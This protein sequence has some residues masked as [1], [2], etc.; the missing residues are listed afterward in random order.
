MSVRISSHWWQVWARGCS[1]SLPD[2]APVP[3]HESSLCLHIAPPLSPLPYP[4]FTVPFMGFC[5]NWQRQQHQ[6]NGSNVS[7]CCTGTAC[8]VWNQVSHNKMRPRSGGSN[9]SVRFPLEILVFMINP[10]T[11][12][13]SALLFLSPFIFLLL[14]SFA[15]SPP[16]LPSVEKVNIIIY[17][18]RETY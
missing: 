2:T 5:S 13:S 12:D 1:Q 10:R 18:Q 3:C 6:R 15:P 14:A 9:Y 17:H 7:I 11:E 4:I 16:L 8:Q